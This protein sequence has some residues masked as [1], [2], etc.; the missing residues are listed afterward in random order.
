M[1]LGPMLDSTVVEIAGRGER[2]MMKLG[3][4]LAGPGQH[5]V[6]WR[7]RLSRRTQARACVIS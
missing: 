2:V 1:G 3:L 5:V 6:A 4:F 7:V